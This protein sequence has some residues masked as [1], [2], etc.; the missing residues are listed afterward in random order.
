[1]DAEQLIDLLDR[2]SILLPEV[3]AELRSRVASLE[4]PIPAESFARRLVESDLLPSALIPDLLRQLEI[5]TASPPP[6]NPADLALP[7][8]F[9]RPSRSE[10][11]PPA[12]P[13]LPASPGPNAPPTPPPQSPPPTPSGFEPAREPSLSTKHL[14]LKKKSA[15]PRESKLILAG[16]SALLVLLLLGV[17]F[18]GSIFQRSAD[19]MLA[20]ANTSYEQGSYP[21]TIAAY[22]EF[23]DAFPGHAGVPT[24]K[25]RRALARIR[26]QVDAKT[27]WPQAF[28]TAASEIDS[29]RE[30][31][32][33]FEESK[34]E[35]ANLLPKIAAG[36]AERAE[37]ETSLPLLERAEK[38]LKLT[39]ELLPRSLRPES[40]LS[41][42]RQQVSRV[43]RILLRDDRL[44]ETD[45]TLQN[46][47]ARQPF[48]ADLVERSYQAV[49]ALRADYPELESDQRWRSMLRQISEAEANA[50]VPIPGD[51]LPAFST[52]DA[53][54]VGEGVCR[55]LAVLTFASGADK[56]ESGDS[57]PVFFSGSGVFG[58]L[59]GDNGTPLWQRNLGGRQGDL[60]PFP[61]LVPVP[62]PDGTALIV[63]L[64][65]HDLL[66]VDG[67]TGKTLA[68][69]SVGEP[70]RFSE[71]PAENPGEDGKH[72]ALAA[73]S[74]KL[75]IVSLSDNSLRGF[76]LPQELQ[77]APLID[78]GT[79]TV[80]QFADRET[81]YRIP[82]EGEEPVRSVF[83]GQKPESLR[84]LPR[85]SGSNLLLVRPA[86]TAPPGSLLELVSTEGEPVQTL[87]VD[88]LVDTPVSEDAGYTAAVS[89]IGDLVLFEQTGDPKKPLRQVARGTAGSGTERRGAL[90]FALLFG[91]QLWIAD[92][93]FTRFEPQLSQSR[94]LPQRALRQDIVTPLPVFRNEKTLFHAFRRPGF[95]GLSVEAVD[96]DD[97]RILWETDLLD[98]I[99][100]E[101]EISPE[102]EVSLYTSS[103]KHYRFRPDPEH[104]G[105]QGLPDARL[106]A[107]VF[108]AAPLDGA[109]PLRDGFSAWFSLRRR[110]DS[111]EATA[112]GR[113][114]MIYDP[115]AGSETRFI[116]RRLTA[117]LAA[118]PLALNGFLLAPLDDGQVLLLDAA[119]GNSVAEPFVPVLDPAAPARWSDPVFWD[120][121][122]FLIIR[123]RDEEPA[124]HLVV[125]ETKEGSPAR[126]RAELTHKI[127]RPAITSPV[128]LGN[129][130]AWVD[131]E[132]R[133][134][135]L[136][137]EDG[138]AV[139]EA[140]LKLPG[141]PV[142]GP[143]ACGG[144]FLLATANGRLHVVSETGKLAS[145]EASV[146]VGRPCERNGT[147]LLVD[148]DGVLRALAPAA[149][150]LS[151]LA[152]TGVPA[153]VGPVLHEGRVLLGGNDGTLYEI[154]L[155]D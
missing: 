140:S 15:N 18:S 2:K 138:R 94:L 31:I 127:D 38:A 135:L 4:E 75:F 112:S 65:R 42:T 154:V 12:P 128:R 40:E 134:Q 121:S 34:A 81:L 66:R 16:I 1:M 36:L 84:V 141:P 132:H 35:L 21:Q 143:H 93:Q 20:A 82:L 46:L 33:F 39:D 6:E 71:I 64:A 136:R 155:P 24:A 96:M 106:P 74:G 73:R 123:N 139:S 126:L 109:V 91:R 95:G 76:R 69:W 120:E 90:R 13:S 70:F 117:S 67:R 44:N 122:R 104:A 30:E 55:P 113:T 129:R 118:R 114:I 100:L 49:D 32:G 130:V 8:T 137:F 50:V 7:S 29:V 119:T 86:A 11:I 92:R 63:D 68:R 108:G 23:I 125:Y 133:L 79:K 41:K 153:S 61:L 10:A 77:S 17:F 26:Q 56:T 152:E 146:P 14:R 97:T 47:L 98:P 59:R 45:R 78:P 144:V 102:G 88:G 5:E 53:P 149:P 111:P 19:R 3:I 105:F 25:I 150:A 87:T 80:F 151:V 48:V 110:G 54:A 103:G 52:E 57:F 116:P 72:V 99:V 101:P 148:R 43:R 22:T 51:E 147:I 58:A 28:E 124:L 145:L 115:R 89:D 27:D 107:G 9:S 37:A 83:F 85:M 131:T 142:W 62:G 60:L